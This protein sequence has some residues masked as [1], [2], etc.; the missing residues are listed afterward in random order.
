MFIYKY[1]YSSLGYIHKNTDNNLE[2]CLQINTWQF[3]GVSTNLH[4][5]VSGWIYKYTPNSF[6]VVCSN[7]HQQV[8]ECIIKYAPDSLGVYPKT[9]TWWFGT[10]STNIHLAVLEY[11]FNKTLEFG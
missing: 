2:L 8:R 1:T 7:M 11:I 4:L 10:V 3:N 9:W 5:P 6:G